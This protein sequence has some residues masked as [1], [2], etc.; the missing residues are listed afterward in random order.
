MP[1]ADDFSGM[2]TSGTTTAATPEGRRRRVEL[3]RYL[4]MGS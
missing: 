2:R 4:I 3:L 1:V